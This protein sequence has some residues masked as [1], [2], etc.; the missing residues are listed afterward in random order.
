[1]SIKDIIK[2]QETLR[3]VAK[4]AF[5]SVDIDKSG[6]IDSQELSKVMEGI[7]NDLGVAPPSKE[8]VMEV[9]KHLDTDHSGKIDFDEFIVLIK[10]ILTAM[11]ESQ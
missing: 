5:E 4:V 11:A 6:Q 2:D 7:S 10:D 1:M 3:K 9:L 8:E